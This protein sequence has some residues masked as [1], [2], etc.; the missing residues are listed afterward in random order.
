MSYSPLSLSAL[1]VATIAIEKSVADDSD[2]VAI[3]VV[4]NC[5][6]VWHQTQVP[7]P[8]HAPKATQRLHVW[9]R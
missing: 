8:P 4:N 3:V 5:K 2:V 9:C 1:C 6:Y 7:R